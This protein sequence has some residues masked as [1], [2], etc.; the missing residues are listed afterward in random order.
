MQRNRETKWQR[1]REKEKNKKE[2]YERQEDKGKI[3]RKLGT[4]RK[5]DRVTQRGIPIERQKMFQTSFKL[6]ILSVFVK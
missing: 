1:K 3:E 5:R 6:K 4:E 2:R